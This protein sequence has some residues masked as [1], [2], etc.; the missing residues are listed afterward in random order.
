MEKGIGW[1]KGGRLFGSFRRTGMGAYKG[2]KVLCNNGA[3]EGLNRRPD[4]VY[5]GREYGEELFSFPVGDGDIYGI[6]YR[7]NSGREE[8]EIYKVGTPDPVETFSSFQ[9]AEICA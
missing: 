7:S 9:R 1:V 2:V 3:W 5:E 6:F 4:A 8:V